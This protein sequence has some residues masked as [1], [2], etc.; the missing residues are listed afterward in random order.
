MCAFRPHCPISTGGFHFRTAKTPPPRPLAPCL[1]L[2]AFSYAVRFINTTKNHT[3]RRAVPTVRKPCRQSRRRAHPFA[4]RKP[5]RRV[6]KICRARSADRV[7]G[8]PAP[9]PIFRRRQATGQPCR[10]VRERSR[11]RGSPRHHA[12]KRAATARRCVPAIRTGS[13]PSRSAAAPCVPFLCAV[14]T[15]CR[16]RQG[17]GFGRRQVRGVPIC[18]RGDRRNRPRV[19]SAAN[20]SGTVTGSDKRKRRAPNSETRHFVSL[21]K[22]SVLLLRGLLRNL[23]GLLRRGGFLRGLRRNLRRRGFLRRG[24]LLHGLGFLLCF[25]ACTVPTRGRARR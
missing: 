8:A 24:F 12:A 7:T 19:R 16:R 23:R 20:G 10:Q 21:R 14:A 4:V 5:C 9:R 11:V 15:V 2:P 25:P 3:R 1:R 18:R 6:R 17:D 22:V 13:R